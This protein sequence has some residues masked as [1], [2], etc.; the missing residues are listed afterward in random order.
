M[1]KEWKTKIILLKLYLIGILIWRV[2]CSDTQEKFYLF[3]MIHQELNTILRHHTNLSA[4]FYVTLFN[5]YVPPQPTSRW[6][7]TTTTVLP[8]RTTCDSWRPNYALADSNWYIQIM[9]KVMLTILQCI[10]LGKVLLLPFNSLFSRTTWVRR[11]QKGKPF[12]ILM[13]QEMMGWQRYQ[14]NHMQL[15]CTSLQ[16][17]NQDGCSSWHPTNSVKLLKVK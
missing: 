10:L 1:K 15:I 8:Y 6:T 11:H 3:K 16:T 17:D 5:F 13:K 4:G 14:L 2:L 12:W 7:T 9:E